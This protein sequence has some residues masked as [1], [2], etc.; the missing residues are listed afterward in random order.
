LPLETVM[1]ITGLSRADLLQLQSE[2]HPRH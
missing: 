1:A 2:G